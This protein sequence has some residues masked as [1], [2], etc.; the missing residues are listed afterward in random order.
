MLLGPP[1]FNWCFLFAPD[2]SKLFGALGPLT[3]SVS[4][5]L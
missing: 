5:R 3:E 2:F 4:A 1:G